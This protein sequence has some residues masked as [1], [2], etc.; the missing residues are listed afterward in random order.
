MSGTERGGRTGGL[1][2][3]EGRALHGPA[4]GVD[5]DDVQGHGRQARQG[6]AGARGGQPLLPG[7]PAAGRLVPDPVAGDVGAGRHPV[8]VEGV[9]LNLGE[10]QAGGRVQRC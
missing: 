1:L 8:D 10:V 9:C 6:E 7:S 3:D 5:V 2:A 4:D